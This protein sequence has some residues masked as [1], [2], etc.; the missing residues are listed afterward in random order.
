MSQNMIDIMET[1]FNAC[2]LIILCTLVVKMIRGSKSQNIES[3]KFIKTLIWSFVF[4]ALGDTGHVG[5]RVF[6]FFN[7]G[8]AANAALLGYGKLATSITLT[9]FYALLVVVWKIRFNKEYNSFTFILFACA[10]IRLVLLFFPG[11]QWTS[12]T[13]PFDWTIYRNIPF[14]I[15]GLGADMLILNSASKAKDH[16]FKW[17]GIM[18]LISYAFYTP[19]ILFAHK[20]PAIGALMIPKTVAYLAA[21][22]IA[23]HGVFKSSSSMLHS[24]NTAKL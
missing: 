21:A 1:V 15:L 8:F 19:V 23:W 4:L 22:F 20:V 18:I 2:Y 14:I 6:A 5:F 7:G 10:L 11:N 17:I 24:K 12:A 16:T 3:S 9:L 13:A